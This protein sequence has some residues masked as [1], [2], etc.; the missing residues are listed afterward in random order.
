MPKINKKRV[1]VCLGILLAI[2]VLAFLLYSPII[3]QEGNPMPLVNGIMRLNFTQDK[4]VKLD[5]NK[6]LY[7]TKSNG[8]QENIKSYMIDKGYIFTEQMG[9]GYFFQ[10]TTGER[11]VAIHKYYSRFYSLWNITENINNLDNLENDN[12]LW[13]TITTDDGA[14]FQYPKEILAEYISEAQWPPKLKIE[15][16]VFVCDPSGNEIQFGGQTELRLVDNRSYCVTKESEG[17]A[18]SIYTTYTYVFPKNNQIG[19]ITFTLRFVQ[20]QN[21][22]ESKALECENERAAF[23]VDGMV[24]RIAQSIKIKSE[25]LS[26]AEQLQDCLPKSD[27]GSYEKCN[28]LLETIRNFDDCVRAGFSIMKSNPP[29]C[30]TVDDRTFIDETNS[31]WE[32]ALAIL[33]NCEVKSVF[34]THSKLVTLKLKNG[35]KVIVYEPQIDD[36]MHVADN[37]QGKCGNIIMATE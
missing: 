37:L 35:N 10:S 15:N 29:Q 23:D 4:I 8:G 6:E 36:V 20:C 28:E 25:Q 9:S 22:D 7:L 33:N 17:A 19:V 3:F 24:D 2:F 30:I 27:M 13:V 1:F 18:G 12:N 11:A 26:I 21:Y 31:T 34:Q 14:D 32:A 16:E 5:I